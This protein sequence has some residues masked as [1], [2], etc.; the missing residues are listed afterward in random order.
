[1]TE[2]EEAAARYGRGYCRI[3]VGNTVA[4]GYGRI[5]V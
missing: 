2:E 5:T 3:T 1:M 4:K